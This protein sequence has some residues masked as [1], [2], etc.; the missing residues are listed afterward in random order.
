MKALREISST[1]TN[2]GKFICWPRRQLWQEHCGWQEE[3]E[4]K[5]LQD[6]S[7]MQ[8]EQKNPTYL[9][10]EENTPHFTEKK[11]GDM[12]SWDRARSVGCSRL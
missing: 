5:G 8:K 11:N 2:H 9:Y 3:V 12:G 4:G 6:M 1:F 7:N 10:G